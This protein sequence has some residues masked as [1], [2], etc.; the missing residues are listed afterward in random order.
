MSTIVTMT[1]D[2]LKELPPLT[3]AEKEIIWNARPI[4]DEDCPKQTKEQLAQFKPYYEAHAI[5]QLQKSKRD[6]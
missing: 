6:T 5:R 3:A 2:E 4:H 1:L